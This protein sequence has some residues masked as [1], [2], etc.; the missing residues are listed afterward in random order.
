M[1]KYKYMIVYADGALE[2]GYI[3]K[4]TYLSAMRSLHQLCNQ[5]INLAHKEISQTWLG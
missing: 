5:R 3:Q 2:E 1:N 4:E